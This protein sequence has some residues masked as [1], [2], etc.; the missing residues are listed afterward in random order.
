MQV[1][2]EKVPPIQNGLICQQCGSVGMTSFQRALLAKRFCVFT[3]HFHNQV[4]FLVKSTSNPPNPH[5]IHQVDFLIKSH[6]L[7][8][9]SNYKLSDLTLKVL[10][11]NDGDVI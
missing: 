3:N 11:L 10:F 5:Q 9:P 1:K 2:I 6:P 7:D 8:A 4:D